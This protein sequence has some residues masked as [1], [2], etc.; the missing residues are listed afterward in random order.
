VTWTPGKVPL[1]T[2][3][4]EGDVTDWSP[5]LME[6]RDSG[7][8]DEIAKTQQSIDAAFLVVTQL[9]GQRI[10]AP[11]SGGGY[12]QPAAPAAVG[13]GRSCAHG[14]MKYFEGIG[15]TGKAYK[16]Y[17]CPIKADGCAAQWGR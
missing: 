13:D 15:K 11:A 3:R 16:R 2:F 12:Q 1:I 10:D 14:V 5:S 17:D 9:G 7:I 8:A 6:F 4:P